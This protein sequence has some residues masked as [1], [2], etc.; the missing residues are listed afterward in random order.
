MARTEIQRRIVK[1]QA[2]GRVGVGLAAPDESA[3]RFMREVENDSEF[4]KIWRPAVDKFHKG[5]AR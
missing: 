5:N 3:M 1:L 2:E 4:E